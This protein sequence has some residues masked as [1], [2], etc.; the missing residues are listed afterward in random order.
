MASKV[1]ASHKP[2]VSTVRKEVGLTLGCHTESTCEFCVSK[3]G[4]LQ[5]FPMEMG[6][7]ALYQQSCVLNM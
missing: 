3:R 5:G 1:M 7:S 6:M 2:R 4:D